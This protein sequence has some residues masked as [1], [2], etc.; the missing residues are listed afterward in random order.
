MYCKLY[1][2]K[3]HLNLDEDFTDDDEYLVSLAEVAEA[4]VER[5]IDNKLKDL[6]VSGGE[7]PSPLRHAILLLI[8]NFY[9]NRESVAAAQ[10]HEIPLSYSYLLDLFKNYGGGTK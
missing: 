9:E 1:Q 3:Q 5:H 7:L 4:T 8:S 6:C 10:L 2:I